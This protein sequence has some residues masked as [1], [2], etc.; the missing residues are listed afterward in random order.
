MLTLNEIEDSFEVH[1]RQQLEDL[2]DEELQAMLTDMRTLRRY[3]PPS[4]AASP[5]REI[6]SGILEAR[7]PPPPVEPAIEP[8]EPALEAIP[9]VAPQ[10]TPETT[11]DEPPEPSPPPLPAVAT[12]VLTLPEDRPRRRI[13]LY[14]GAALLVACA[15][16]ILR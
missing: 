7:R 13:W 16:L 10:D 9:P 2:P 15:Y 5:A 1:F 3:A 11:L 12:T 14:A 4:L 6:V 8:A